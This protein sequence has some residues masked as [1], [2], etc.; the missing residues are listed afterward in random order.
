MKNDEAIHRAVL[1]GTS[2]AVIA[3]MLLTVTALQAADHTEPPAISD[4]KAADIADLYTWH[5]EGSLVAVLTFGGP[6]APGADQEPTVSRD[7]LYGIHVDNNDDQEAEVDIRARF[8]QD[9]DGNW[10]VRVA[11]IPGADA[12]LVGPVGQ[13]LP[14]EGDGAKVWTGL[15]EDPF[16][17]DLQGFQDSVANQSLTDGDGNLYFDSSRDFFAGQNITALVVEV[18]VDAVTADDDV[19]DIW[20]TT[21]LHANGG[22]Q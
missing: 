5:E 10:G 9:D 11:G 7:V 22:S 1:G 2:V 19:L 8:G 3:V 18:P 12:P 17:F 20:A 16:F 4:K 21:S 14:A 15:R 6:A 13:T